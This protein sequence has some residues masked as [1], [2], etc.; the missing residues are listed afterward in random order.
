MKYV[1]GVDLGGTTTSVALFKNNIGLIKQNVLPTEADKGIDYILTKISLALIKLIEEYRIKK[2]N[3]LGVGFGSPGP[4]NIKNGIVFNCPNLKGWKNVPLKKL[5]ES[6]T[7]LPVFIENDANAAALGEWRK[8]SGQ[9]VRNMLFVTLGTGIGGGL[10]INNQL[11]SG[12]DD[13]GGEIGHMTLFPD[14]IK[15]NCGNFGCIEMYASATGIVR[16]TKEALKSGK[17]SILSVF[18]NNFTS[19]DVYC[20]ALKK[21]KLAFEIMADTGKYLGIIFSSIA[22]LL[23]LDMIVVGGNVS[24]AGE[25]LLRPIRKEVQARV[26]Y[27]AN[28]V[29]IIKARLGANA[30]VIGAACTVLEKL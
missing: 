1:I 19:K 17:K 4:L 27:P 5:M 14:G 20:A 29:K 22:S 8:G 24:N 6:K 10:I 23:D 12:K 11:Y 18:G 2:H 9:G 25:T 26:M 21:D 28:K 15:C 7:G 16:R 13:A 30:G 3:I